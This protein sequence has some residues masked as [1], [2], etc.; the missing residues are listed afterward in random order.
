MCVHSGGWYTE[1]AWLFQ[2]PEKL[3]RVHGAEDDAGPAEG[4]LS[5][6]PPSFL[7]AAVIRLMVTMQHNKHHPAA[8]PSPSPPFPMLGGDKLRAVGR[9]DHVATTMR[10]QDTSQ[11]RD[12]RGARRTVRRSSL[13][14][15]L[16]GHVNGSQGR[17]AGQLR[18]GSL[19]FVGT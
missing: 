2:T 9:A 19:L 18:A 13:D 7:T 16:D 11:L 15:P 5:P 14:K 3:E 17:K 8:F 1:V 12:G 4:L 10:G 6:P